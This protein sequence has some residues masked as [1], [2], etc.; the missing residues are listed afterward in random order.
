MQM[1]TKRQKCINMYA[2]G[3]KAELFDIIN[4]LLLFCVPS[5]QGFGREIL[6]SNV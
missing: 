2:P 3:D 4:I 6:A 1:S 5:H